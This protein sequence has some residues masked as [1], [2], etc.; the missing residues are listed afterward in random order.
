MVVQQQAQK[1]VTPHSG[2]V[3]QTQSRPVASQT[4]VPVVPMVATPTG[5][6]QPLAPADGTTA[7]IIP[8]E[9]VVSAGQSVA[10]AVPPPT[11]GRAVKPGSLPIKE[12]VVQPAARPP[13]P[14][15]AAA[16]AVHY[17]IEPLVPG[18]TTPVIYGQTTEVPV[19][20][21]RT[22][23]SLANLPVYHTEVAASKSMPV[24]TTKP[25]AI[26]PAQPTASIE[27][28]GIAVN[29]QGTPLISPQVHLGYGAVSTTP[30]IQTVV[31]PSSDVKLAPQTAT[32][33]PSN[34]KLSKI[35]TGSTQMSQTVK[36]SSSHTR[37]QDQ[38]ASAQLEEIGKNISDAF[39]SSNE[40][41]LIAAFEDAWKKFQ[42]NGKR[43]QSSNSS[44][45]RKTGGQTETVGKPIPPPNA[46]VVSVPGTTSRLSLIR[47]TYSRSKMPGV[48]SSAPADQLVCVPAETQTRLTVAAPVVG[49]LQQKQQHSVQFIYCSA[50]SVQPQ[51]YPGASEHPGTALYAV[52][53]N[54]ARSPY[55]HIVKQPHRS[56][57][58]V[59]SRTT[60]VQSSG[61]YIPAHASD[62]SLT[63]KHQ[64][65][66]VVVEPV[67]AGGLNKSVVH[68]PRSQQQII[69]NERGIPVKQPEQVAVQHL[70][71]LKTKPQTIVISGD[72]Q[73]KQQ[74]APVATASV[75]AAGKAARQ[76]ALCTKEATYLCSGC[77]RIWYCGKECQVCKHN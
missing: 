27:I 33:S 1:A 76:C 73:Q 64:P 42:A 53:P 19:A 9:A 62:I 15:P 59:G 74:K 32:G 49:D 17:I 4:P 77:H 63:S 71:V 14:P 51:V 48:Q 16:P 45:G 54:N 39:A 34:P 10:I 65:T 66:A 8:T 20:V 7:Y 70:S 23:P 36:S 13:P 55:E 60:Q 28:Q 56:G 57:K 30:Y 46:E 35:S 52:A 6:P 25:Y 11:A 37:T 29:Q 72:H 26:V 43:Y 68:V 50:P 41:M 22:Q 61:I 18:A 38:Q 12:S 3:K 47:P 21:T 58:L 67:T 75:A 31:T 44:S 40:Q 24:T 2:G 69:I 5:Y